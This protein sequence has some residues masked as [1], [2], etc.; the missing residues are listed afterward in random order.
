RVRSRRRRKRWARAQ[1][2]QSFPYTSNRLIQPFMPA[3][4]L[5]HPPPLLAPAEAC[6]LAG[7][8][9][10]TL[11]RWADQGL[12]AHVKTAGGHRRFVR[13]ELERFLARQMRRVREESAPTGKGGRAHEGW[14]ERLLTGLPH[15]VEAE[16]MLARA[17][18]GSWWRVADELGA[19]LVELG[20]RWERGEL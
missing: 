14:I 8:G 10:T 2:I 4:E 6:H 16:L 5:P 12:L 1:T 20:L 7:V 18:G 11:K 19:V 3:R 13:V 17:R 15:E 9:P